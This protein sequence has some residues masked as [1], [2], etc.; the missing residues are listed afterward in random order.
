LGGGGEV[1]ALLVFE[2]WLM[3]LEKPN[4]LLLAVGFSFFGLC[5]T[6]FYKICATGKSEIFRT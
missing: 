1:K 6:D 4:V 5:T 3:R 2:R